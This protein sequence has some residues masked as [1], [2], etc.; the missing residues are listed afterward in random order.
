MTFSADPKENDEVTI[1]IADAREYKYKATAN[2]K[3]A[4]VVTGLVV[5]IKGYGDTDVLATP[6]RIESV[7]SDGQG[8]GRS[9]QC[10]GIYLYGFDRSADSGGG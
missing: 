10:G 6:I 5:A 1:K 2:Q 9:W 7:D 3:I 4:D 8:F